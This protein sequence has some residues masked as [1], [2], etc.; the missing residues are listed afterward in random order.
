[1]KIDILHIIRIVKFG[2]KN[3]WLHKLRSILTMLGI[4]LGV[5]S[6]IAML[7]IG[8]G[9]SF[10][11]KEMIKQLGSNNIIIQSVKPSEQAASQNNSFLDVYGLTSSDFRKIATIPA[12]DKIVPTWELKGD[13]WYLDKNTTGRIVGT[14][15]DYAETTNMS[16][17]NGR[18][19]NEVDMQM[20]KS[21]AV[22]GSSIK[23]ALFRAT[24]PIGKKIKIKSNYFTVVGVV[25]S[26]VFSKGTESFEAEDINFDVYIPLNTARIYFGEFDVQLRTRQGSWVK[27]H[28]FIAKVGDT[29]KI[30]AASSL[31][32]S[33]LESAHKKADY[34]IFVPLAQLKQEEHRAKIFSIVLGS[35]AAISLVVGGVGIMN[36]ML[37]TV[38]ERTREIGIRRAL[39]AKRRD[40][41]YQFVTEA[42]ILSA[43]G[44]FIGVLV[45]IIIPG[46]VSKFAEMV[47]IVTLWSVLLAFFISVAVGITFGIYPARKA[48]FLDPIEALR[49]E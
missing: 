35:I 31:I 15:T 42:V 14:T 43:T 13:V 26:K 1:M 38:T 19:L 49:Y 22:I 23:N 18:F 16:V 32:N 47:T 30:M 34:E 25:A 27:F 10:E 39:G 17:D 29:N 24:D 44:G 36:I 5:A 20:S 40:I 12:I 7:A 28:R 3:L 37:A 48:A 46:I 8:E 11:Q 6:V 2:G 41:I 21:V 33:I 4:V 9:A 45:G